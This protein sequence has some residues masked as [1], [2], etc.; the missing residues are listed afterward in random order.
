MM[1]HQELKDAMDKHTEEKK[2]IEDEMF[3]EGE[4]LNA[5]MINKDRKKLEKKTLELEVEENPLAEGR[6]IELEEEIY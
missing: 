2:R 5:Y 6:I 4:K 1:L 3:E